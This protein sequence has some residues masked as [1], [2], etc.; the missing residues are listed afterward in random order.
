MRPLLLCILD[1]FGER[2]ETKGNA[3]KE[4]Y[5]PNY[6]YLK[7]N[8]PFS[9]LDASGEAVGLPKGQMGNSEVGHSNIGA[10]RVLYGPLMRINNSIKD[11]SFF[12]NKNILEAI[13]KAKG[14]KLHIMGLLSDGGI[15]S[16]INHLMALLDL[17]KKQDIKEVYIHAFTDGRDTLPN[18]SIKYLDKLQDKL[19]KL[20]IGKIASIS[21]RYYAMDRDNRW[22]RIKKVY[23]AIVCGNAKE[24]SDYH[25]VIEENYSKGVTDEFIVPSLLD[26]NGLIEDGD[27]VIIFNFRPDRLRE[28]GMTL[29]NKTFKEFETKNIDI[30]LLTMMNVSHD[31]K[32][33]NAFEEL[34]INNTLGE[35][36][37]TLGYKQLR[38]AETE[39]YAHVTYFFDGGEEK[40]FKGEEKIL[41]PSPH[42]ATYDLKPEMSA[43]MITDRL[44]KEIDNYDFIL[45]NFANSDMVGHTGNYTATVEA[46]EVI[47]K[48]IGTIYKK[49]LEKDGIF[50]LT[51][52]HGNSDY[53]IDDKGNAVTSHSISKVPFIVTLN[54][55]TLKNGS[56][57]DIA[58]T[59][60]TILGEKIPE[61][62]TGDILIK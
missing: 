62:M 57:P 31:V 55:I 24:Y 6:N 20:K 8:Y 52:D 61:E 46:L 9:L 50:I 41:I 33:T 18:V 25:T 37:A 51:A 54:D 27:S 14:H 19:N 32:C 15:H 4:A 12:A 38:I 36:L 21:G 5:M 43:Y 28:I 39:K 48:C 45:I 13:K 17:V 58:P 1:G 11:G 2:N 40:T 60:L 49:V 35:Y 23:D 7:K 34:K 42:V 26:K 3:V 56:L 30:S 59:I 22:D 10:G 29:T 47:D 44:L 53:M 16:H